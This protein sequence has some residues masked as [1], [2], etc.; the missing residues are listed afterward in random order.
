MCQSHD[1]TVVRRLGRAALFESTQFGA[2][3]ALR[4]RERYGPAVQ[5]EQTRPFNEFEELPETVRK[6]A[7]E[8]EQHATAHTPYQK[9]AAGRVYPGPETLKQREL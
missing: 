5:V 1:E 8:Y 9:F 7:H 4:L 2:F 6:A 3:L